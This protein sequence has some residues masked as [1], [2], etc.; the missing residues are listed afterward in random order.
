M[1]QRKPKKV[2]VA[3]VIASA[4]KHHRARLKLTQKQ[5]AEKMRALGFTSWARTT[6]SE[7]EGSGRRRQVSVPE[8]LGLAIVFGVGLDDLLW[9]DPMRLELVPGGK[10]LDEWSDFF[11][12]LLTPEAMT[13]VSNQVFR[14]MIEKE[15]TRMYT[16]MIERVQAVAAELRGTAGWFET[17][18]IGRL[19]APSTQEQS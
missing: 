13:K 14:S 9:E 11:S 18:A 12:L 15:Y 19:L 5:L 6:V 7:V 10:T 16:T 2:A 8:L 17:E 1:V 4:S 3:D